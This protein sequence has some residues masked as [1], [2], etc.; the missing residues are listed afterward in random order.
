MNKRLY[1]RLGALVLVFIG[2]GY[3]YLKPT[4]VTDLNAP[5]KASFYQ[6]SSATVEEKQNW[7]PGHYRYQYEDYDVL[8]RVGESFLSPDGTYSIKLNSI[9][10][11]PGSPSIAHV[12]FTVGTHTYTKEVPAYSEISAE[13]PIGTIHVNACEVGGNVHPGTTDV[14]EEVSLMVSIGIPTKTCPSLAG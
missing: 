9:T 2:V 14:T 10:D 4:S 1:I 6:P 13:T 8:L 7:F 12:T 11:I 5:S 3:W